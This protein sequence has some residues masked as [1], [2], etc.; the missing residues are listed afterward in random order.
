MEISF[1]DSTGEAKSYRLSDL[2]EINIYEDFQCKN[3]S[4]CTLVISP[5]SAYLSL[6]PYNEGQQSEKDCF[7]FKATSI[8]A[9]E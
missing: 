5:N 7:Y 9:V 8:E 2:T 3:I 6:D 4:Q 1:T